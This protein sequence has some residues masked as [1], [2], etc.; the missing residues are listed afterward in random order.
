MSGPVVT[1]GHPT[2]TA[3]V[4]ALRVQGLTTKQ[5]ANR[6]GIETKTVTALEASARR[7]GSAKTGLPRGRYMPSP[8][9]TV[10]MDVN[11]IRALRPHAAR[12]ST[13]VAH[14]AKQLL[15][16]LADDNLVDAL[17]DDADQVPA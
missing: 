15:A 14:L 17:L 6:I 11:T 16:V 4:Q 3:A 5:I 10:E 12:R 1:L 7:S 2:R 9:N 13:T 8:Q